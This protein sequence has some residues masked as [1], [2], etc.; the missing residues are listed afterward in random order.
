MR[1]YDVAVKDQ[2]FESVAD[3]LSDDRRPRAREQRDT[4]GQ[5]PWGLLFLASVLVG[6][7]AYYVSRAVMLSRAAACDGRTR[8]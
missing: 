6:A 8:R 5:L 2:S 1:Y 4:G 7:V 3:L